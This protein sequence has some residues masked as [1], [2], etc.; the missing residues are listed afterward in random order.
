MSLVLADR[1]KVR[2]RTEGTG[3]FLL[4]NI[5]FGF[6]GF[7][8]I[9]DGNETYY[10]IVDNLG[11]WE[12]GRGTYFAIG[13]TLARDTVLQS[14][15]ADT[16]VNF[17]SGAKN[18]YCTYP[19]SI[20]QSV[21]T[22]GGLSSDSFK[23]ISVSGQTNVVADSATDT[24]T[25]VAGT[26]I[27][28]TTN[29]TA[30][31]ITFTSTPGNVEFVQ[32]PANVDTVIKSSTDS[33]ITSMKLFVQIEGLVDGDSTGYHTQ[34]CDVIVVKR[35]PNSTVD[36]SVYGIVHTSTLPLAIIDAAWNAVDST[37][38]VTARPTSTTNEIRVRATLIEATTTD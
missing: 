33:F 5:V 1:V 28:I 22:G 19:A 25:L 20:A 15:N 2:S 23:T 4:E 9:G 16:F 35:I 21:V 10:G 29:S 37:I 32:C 27:T 26:G 17:G 7:D 11:N 31:T 18:V 14:S 12:V 30:D 6:Q 34:A 38:D 8:V 13:P 3:D 24:L 36:H